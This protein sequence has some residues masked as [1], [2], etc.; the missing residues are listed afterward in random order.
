[1]PFYQ[2]HICPWYQKFGRAVYCCSHYL[3]MISSVL[4]TKSNWPYS[5]HPITLLYSAKAPASAATPATAR[6]RPV[7]IARAAPAFEANPVYAEADSVGLTIEEMIGRS[8]VDPPPDLVS[9]CRLTISR[10]SIKMEECV[11]LMWCGGRG[12][13]RRWVHS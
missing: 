1:M 2:T 6:C 7:G 3:S 9:P 13:A 4:T 11:L 5:P 12:G 8:V 10:V